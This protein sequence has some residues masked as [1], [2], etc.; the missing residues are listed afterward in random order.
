MEQVWMG[1][2]RR[3]FLVR[4]GQSA[5]VLAMAPLL[6]RV[7][8]DDAN[9][10]PAIVANGRYD[11]DT[12]YNRVGT[13]CA[14]WDM[15]IRDEHM[16][17][18]VAGMGIADM[19][20]ECAPV[21][22]EALQKRVAH[23][24]WGYGMLDIDLLFGT[25]D[26]SPFLKGII[27]WNRKRYGITGIT[28]KNLGVT[29]GVHS[30]IM[31][32]LRTFAPPGSKVLMVTPIYNVFYL[33]L[34]RSKLSPNESKMEMVNGRHEIDWAD[35]EKRASDPNTKTSI[36]CN[37]HNPVGRVWSKDELHRYGEICLKHNVRVLSDE[38]HCD[39][40]AKGQRYTPFST[41][42]D[43][44]IVDNSIT[45]KAASKSFSLAG[46]KCAWFFATDPEV[47]KQ[48]QSWNHSEISTLGFVSSQAVYAGGEDWLN[49]CVDYIDDNQKFANDYIKKNLPLIKVGNQ[50]EGTYLAWLDVSGLADKIGA[51]KMADEENRKPLPIN[52]LTGKPS[53]VHSTDMVAHWV[54]KNAFVYLESGVGFGAGAADYM[55]MNVATSRKT[56]KAALDSVAAAT[57]KLA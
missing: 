34:Y 47:F 33:D 42:G 10:A 48:V 29:T 9:A 5:S 12:P 20:F 44:K 16:P 11:F 19:D 24:N 7:M 41:L 25:A 51:Q 56:L 22:T 32:A 15:V 30:G 4:T 21:V 37:P 57:K 54:A 18:I 40:V 1:T 26:H 43:K 52:F 3:N 31:P 55:R 45:F 27:D 6:A 36:L 38:I 2:D 53:Q 8:S 14:K 35:F 50:P 46:M 39:F 13:D 17:K 49:Q 23:H 28:P